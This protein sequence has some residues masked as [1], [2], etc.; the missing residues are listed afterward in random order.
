MIGAAAMSG[1]IIRWQSG[2][3]TPHQYKHQQSVFVASESRLVARF[4]H[5]TTLSRAPPSI[6]VS[7][8]NYK[9]HYAGGAKVV[10]AYVYVVLTT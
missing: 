4:R 7:A 2:A 6:T 8:V 9:K 1:D 5:K 10:V 3:I